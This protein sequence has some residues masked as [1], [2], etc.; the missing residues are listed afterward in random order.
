MSAEVVDWLLVSINQREYMF[1][2]TKARYCL[3]L[4]VQNASHIM[5]ASN[6]KSDIAF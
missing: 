1:S 4:Q 6:I 5:L 2:K 3:P